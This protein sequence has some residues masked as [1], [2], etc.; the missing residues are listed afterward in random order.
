MGQ[1]EHCETLLGSVYFE[2]TSAA[3]YARL[4]GLVVVLLVNFFKKRQLLQP[5]YNGNKSLL[6]PIYYQYFVILLLLQ[7]IL[8][9]IAENVHNDNGN[10]VL[11]STKVSVYEFF[12]DGICFFLM[13]HG[14]GQYALKRA[15]VFSSLWASVIFVFFMFIFFY[16]DKNVQLAFYIYITF[17]VI[18]ILLYSQFIILPIEILYRRPG[19]KYYALYKIVYN[20]LFLMLVS[21]ILQEIE[22]CYCLLYGFRIFIFF[23]TPLV[24]YKLLLEDSNVSRSYFY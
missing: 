3:N 7:L 22:F 11:L 16:D 14:A 18:V 12:S 4:F 8:T 1:F 17:T 21:C 6:L 15:I 20:I 2:R 5:N 10:Y 13:Q 9:L 19:T 24:L 23:I